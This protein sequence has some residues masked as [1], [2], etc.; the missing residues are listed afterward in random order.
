M[1]PILVVLYPEVELRAGILI[2]LYVEALYILGLFKPNAGVKIVDDIGIT[3]W[4]G[5][6]GIK[7]PRLLAWPTTGCIGVTLCIGWETGRMAD[8]DIIDLTGKL[9]TDNGMGGLT[10][11]IDWV[12]FG[13]VTARGIGFWT[14]WGWG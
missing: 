2:G 12:A 1:L 10:P 4:I 11:L 13:T 8:E 3:C 7:F 14:N 5:C 9:D 6:E